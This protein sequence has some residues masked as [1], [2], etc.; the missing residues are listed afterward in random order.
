[1]PD[2]PVWWHAGMTHVVP[3]QGHRGRT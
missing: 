1:M 3:G 2:K